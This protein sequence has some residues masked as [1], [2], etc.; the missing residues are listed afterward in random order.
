LFDFRQFLFTKVLHGNVFP[1]YK[2]YK[3]CLLLKN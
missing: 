2:Y 1:D 3:Q